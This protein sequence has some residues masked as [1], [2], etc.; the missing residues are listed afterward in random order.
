MRTAIKGDDWKDRSFSSDVFAVEAVAVSLADSCDLRKSAKNFRSP[1]ASFTL[2]PIWFS[3]QM[4][5]CC[6]MVTVRLGM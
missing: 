3:R 5:S 2:P 4:P 6:F 1:T